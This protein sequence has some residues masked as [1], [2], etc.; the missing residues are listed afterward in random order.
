MAYLRQCKDNTLDKEERKR[1]KVNV[2][3]DNTGEDISSEATLHKK[4]HKG[5]ILRDSDK[6][7]LKPGGTLHPQED[8]D[9]H[10]MRRMKPL[11]TRHMWTQRPPT[12]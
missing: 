10:K 7:D 2:D 11:W 3:A 1:D 4:E 5:V 12:K 8:L 9:I 6:S